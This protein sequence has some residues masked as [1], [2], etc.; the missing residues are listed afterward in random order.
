M[1][2]TIHFGG[3]PLFLETPV[4]ILHSLLLFFGRSTHGVCGGHRFISLSYTGFSKKNYPQNEDG[5]KLDP[6]KSLSLHQTKWTK[7]HIWKKIQENNLRYLFLTSETNIF[8]FFVGNPADPLDN[9]GAWTNPSSVNT[10][11]GPVAQLGWTLQFRTCD[12]VLM[13]LQNPKQPV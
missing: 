5:M 11:A 10:W 8:F 3:P 6:P 2:F 7:Q 13:D 9:Q 1:I 12:F 4:C